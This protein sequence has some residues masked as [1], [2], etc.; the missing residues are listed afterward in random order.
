MQ[1]SSL[2]I[3]SSLQNN[4]IDINFHWNQRTLKFF[5]FCRRPFSK[6]RPFARD[7]FFW[8]EYS[9]N[10]PNKND[11]ECNF[12]HYQSI[13]HF[14]ITLDINFHWNQR[15]LKFCRFFRR[16]FSKWRPFARDFFGVRIVYQP[17]LIYMPSFVQI[18]LA[19]SDISEVKDFDIRSRFPWQRRP[20]W[21]LQDL[22]AP[23]EMRIHLPV[24]FSKDR[25]ISLSEFGRTSSRREEEEEE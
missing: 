6:W 9:T 14:K 20:F 25:M 18:P 10:P 5:R 8:S 16:P 19:V 7:F 2:P 3:S 1:F 24:K 13:P 15:T 23:L 21:K 4:P 17:S 12:H 11:P 22:N